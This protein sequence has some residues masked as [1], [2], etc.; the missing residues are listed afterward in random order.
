MIELFSIYFY[1][2]DELTMTEARH[3]GLDPASIIACPCDKDSY[4]AQARR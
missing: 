3:A 2:G 1:L 4:A